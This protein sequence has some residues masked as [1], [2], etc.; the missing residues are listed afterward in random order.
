[1][2]DGIPFHPFN[3]GILFFPAAQGVIADSGFCRIMSMPFVLKSLE[4]LALAGGHGAQ[5]D[6]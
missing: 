2:V 4:F 3:P 1:V 6:L 5:K